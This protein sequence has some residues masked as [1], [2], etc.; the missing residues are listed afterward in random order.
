M[1]TP[2]GEDFL[3]FNFQNFVQDLVKQRQRREFENEIH[4]AFLKFIASIMKGYQ[5]FLRPIKGAPMTEH[6]T[7]TGNLF[8]LDGFLR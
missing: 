4:D 1:C 3:I 2:R 6:A 7:D 5:A 8:D